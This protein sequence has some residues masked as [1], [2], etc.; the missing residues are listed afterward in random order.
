MANL[1]SSSEIISLAQ[2]VLNNTN[3]ET[4]KD[5]STLT[6]IRIESDER[7]KTRSDVESL[8]NRERIM[9]LSLIHI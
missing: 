5:T 2:S 6:E 8:L 3:T 1:A 7:T 4:I 9:F